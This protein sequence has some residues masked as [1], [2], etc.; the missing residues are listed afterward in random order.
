MEEQR[1]PTRWGLWLVVGLV[2]YPLSYGPVAAMLTWHLGIES[3]YGKVLWPVYYPIEYVCLR[4][5]VL[6]KLADWYMSFWV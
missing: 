5:W 2:V 6:G 1:K 4:V 3:I